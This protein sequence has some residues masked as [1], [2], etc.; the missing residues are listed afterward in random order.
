MLGCG[1]E[2]AAAVIEHLEKAPQAVN[3]GTTARK[4]VVYRLIFYDRYGHGPDFIVAVQLGDAL[5]L[6]G[7]GRR[8]HY[9]HV[10]NVKSVEILIGDAA[11]ECRLG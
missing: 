9:D 10:R 2:S 6:C 4:L 5:G 3:I 7:V 11:D 8:Y 1:G